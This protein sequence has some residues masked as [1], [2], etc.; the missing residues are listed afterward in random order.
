MESQKMKRFAGLVFSAAAVLTAFAGIVVALDNQH[1]NS[2]D[3]S[4]MTNDKSAMGEPCEVVCALPENDDELRAL[5]TPEQYRIVRENGTERPFQNAFWDNHKEGLY[6]DVISGEPLFSSKEK[7]DSGTGWPS[8]YAPLHSDNIAEITDNTLGM[9]RT[10]VRSKKANSHLGHLFPDG[11]KPTGL[12]YC[13][14]SGSLKFVPVEQLEEAGLGDYLEH[15]G[16]KKTAKGGAEDAMG[17]N[18]TETVMFGAG[19]FWG[20]EAAFRKIPG[21][22]DA[23]SGYS[24]GDVA[25]PGYKAVCTGTTGHA[26]VV[27]VTYDP[28]KVSFKQLLD[29]F[30]G[31]HNPTQ[32]NRQGPDY[33]EQY[34]SAIF[35]T[36]PEQEKDAKAAIAA[37]T[38]EKRFNKPIATQVVAAKPFYRA[39]EYHQRY[40]EKKGL[41]V[42]H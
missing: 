9:T 21:V 14:N 20:V 4:E 7:F 26:E 2:K 41:D 30:W 3:G 25:D 1:S 42:C 40:L 8:F 10:E 6:L 17:A 32:V 39:E 35:F 11:P 5:L 13:I 12:R 29:A 38:A 31:M 22:I 36:T 33:G 28:S 37:L 24:G 27:Q 15:F 18:Q 34:R 16:R 23:A 19:C